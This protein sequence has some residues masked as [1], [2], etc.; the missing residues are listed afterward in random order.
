MPRCRKA[1]T[2]PESS[3]SSRAAP[4]TLPPD[5]LAAGVRRLG[6]V[7]LLMAGSVLAFAVVERLVVA[8]AGVGAFPGIVPFG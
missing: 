2:P 6:Y 3:A 5:L 1:E 8:R 7:A 4:E